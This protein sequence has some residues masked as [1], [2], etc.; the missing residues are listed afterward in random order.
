MTMR[1]LMIGNVLLALLVLAGCQDI[2]ALGAGP[3]PVYELP[4]KPKIID[5]RVAVLEKWKA[6]DKELFLAL[7][8]QARAYRAIIEAHNKQAI[9]SNK[10]KLEA[11][12]FTQQDLEKLR[13]E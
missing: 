7:Q 3:Q 6:E 5:E 8:N 11:L 13:G 2:K 12:G 4:E 10:K 1:R 9:A